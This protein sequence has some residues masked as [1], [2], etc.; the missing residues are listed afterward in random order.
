MS[1]K[2]RPE[3]SPEGSRRAINGDL[4]GRCTPRVWLAVDAYVSIAREAAIHPVTLAVAFVQSR[5]FPVIP[6]V[7]ATSVEQLDHALDAAAIALSP[8]TL[9]RIGE[10][11]KAHPMPY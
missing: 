5:P 6:I 3:Y 9:A 7:E 8:D 11:Y 10:T 1:G 4:G 2:Y